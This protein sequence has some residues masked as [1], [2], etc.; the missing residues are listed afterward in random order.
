MA[1]AGF[2]KYR[3]TEEAEF[4]LGHPHANHLL[5]VMAYRARRTDHPMNGL[6]AGQCF[7]GDFR[8]L[9][10]TE[11]AY[12]TAK[13]QLQDWGLADF[14]GTNKGTVGTITNSKVYDIN[15]GEGDGQGDRQE[16]GTCDRSVS[17]GV[18]PESNKV[19]DKETGESD[20]NT[21][22]YSGDSDEGDGQT[23]RQ[24]TDQRQVSDER[25]TTNKECKKE[26]KDQKIPLSISK[27][28]EE[29]I[30]A[31]WNEMDL[32][33]HRKIT[34]KCMKHI[35][36]GYTKYGNECKKRGKVPKGITMW[37]C[38]YLV[39]GFSNY[40]TDHHRGLNDR[41]WIANLEYALRPSTYDE[42][43]SIKD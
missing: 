36:V 1:D 33:Q 2:I 21:V 24:V 15:H 29:E 43:T 16:T 38:V 39:Q 19:T 20:E 6:K 22:G 30:L 18:S 17:H 34:D 26:R 31:V 14:K 11:R 25:V 7:L 5:M 10:L 3:R 23:D 28:D 42:V 41:G 9:G 37:V 40:I 27:I 12:R 32:K 4:L 35:K 13:K 8:G